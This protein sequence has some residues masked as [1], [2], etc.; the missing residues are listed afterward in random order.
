M[1]A[2]DPSERAGFINARRRSHRVR[3]SL[4]SDKSEGNSDTGMSNEAT[5]DIVNDDRAST[6]KHQT[7]SINQLSEEFFEIAVNHSVVL[8]LSQLAVKRQISKEK[9][10]YKI[11]SEYSLFK[12]VK[13]PV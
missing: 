6:G 1:P 7:K 13:Y 4:S 9:K 11:F 5:T 12:Y 2:P 8:I 3:R 10:C